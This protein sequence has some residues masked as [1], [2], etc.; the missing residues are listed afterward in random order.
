MRCN[1]MLESSR[2]EKNGVTIYFNIKRK[3]IKNMYMKFSEDGVLHITVPNNIEIDKV[4]NFIRSKI[5]WIMSQKKQLEKIAE[6]KESINFNNG[7]DLYFLG[8]KYNL[9]VIP[10]KKNKVMINESN[11]EISIKERFIGD[12]EYKRK[13][14]EKWLK[15]Q[16]LSLCTEYIEFY[17][18]K[19]KKYNVPFP[20]INA[21]KKSIFRY[22]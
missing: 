20:K 2:I 19:M 15:S 5:N 17:Y 18:E 11:I 22:I 3:K 16:C 10:D 8:K 9:V 6:M 4:D 1:C 12:R 13:I 21:K 7:D 14:Y